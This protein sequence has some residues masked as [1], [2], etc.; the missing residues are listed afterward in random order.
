MTTWSNVVLHVSG[1]WVADLRARVAFLNSW[2]ENGIPAS[3][4][5]SGFFFP[6]AFLTGCLQN[7]ARQNTISIDTIQ[8]GFKVL[9]NK[10]NKRPAYGCIIHGLFLEGCRW[11][12]QL[13]SLEESKPK[14][15]YTGA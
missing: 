3:F 12:E 4:W 8:Y 13:N 15:L 2:I 9:D 7:F 5:I 11:N 14:I 1:A 10:F 6:Q